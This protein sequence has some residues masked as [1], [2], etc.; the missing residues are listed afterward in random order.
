MAKRRRLTKAQREWRPGQTRPPRSV[1]TL[2]ASSVL[3]LEACLMLFFGLT[4]W[5]LN[6]HY[7]YAWWL[8]AGSGLIAVLLVLTCGLLRRPLGYAIGWVLQ[9][10]MISAFLWTAL[11]TEEGLWTPL[12]LIPGLGFLACWWY[13]VRTGA[14]L[15]VEKMERYRMEE[16]LA[17]EREENDS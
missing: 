7:W 4:A 6:Q 1:K 16:Q 10:V 2:F 8:L 15:D 5:G 17:A 12:A 11:I 3:C 14:R 9:F 13:A